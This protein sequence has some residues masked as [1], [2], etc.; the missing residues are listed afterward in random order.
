MCDVLQLILLLIIMCSNSV[1]ALASLFL[2]IV[3]DDK[4]VPGFWVGMVFSMYSIMVVVMSPI[5]G[6][7]VSRVGFANLIAFGLICMGISI[8][9]IGYLVEIENDYYTIALGI[10][11]R[12]LQGAASSSINTSCYSLAANKYKD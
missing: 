8:I 9:P 1:Y 2:P 10:V 3:F 6:K 12:T 5:I 4:A 7:I 11:L